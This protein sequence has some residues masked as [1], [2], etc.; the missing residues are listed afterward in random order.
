MKKRHMTCLNIGQKD[1][2]TQHSQ[3]SKSSC[4]KITLEVYCIPFGNITM[5]FGTFFTSALGSTNNE[6]LLFCT[7][8][9][10]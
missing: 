3:L 7:D 1:T 9:P 10:F 2:S 5:K 8:N 4:G 6:F